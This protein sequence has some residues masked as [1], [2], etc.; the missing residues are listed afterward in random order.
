MPHAEVT[1]PGDTSSVPKARHFVEDVLTAWGRPDHGWTAAL[2]ISELSANCTLHARTAYTVRVDLEGEL[3]RLQVS[4]GSL[5]APALRDYG[6]TATTGRGLRL[7]E[8]LATAWGV[9][10][11]EDGKTVWAVLQADDDGRASVDDEADLDALLATFGE[12]DV[13]QADGPRA[14]AA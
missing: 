12:D 13:E 6:S 3:V 7:V 8:E 11:R 10:L 9:E 1:L 4:D 2:L 14:L 5:R